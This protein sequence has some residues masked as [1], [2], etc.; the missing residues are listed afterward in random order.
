MNCFIFRTS[1]QPMNIS[2]SSGPPFG[3]V[4]QRRA[5]FMCLGLRGLLGLGGLMD[6]PIQQPD[7]RVLLEID[8]GGLH[9]TFLVQMP[10]GCPPTAQSLAF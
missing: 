7:C 8:L 6:H 2:V 4:K 10:G 1:Y 5:M 3:W 9:Q